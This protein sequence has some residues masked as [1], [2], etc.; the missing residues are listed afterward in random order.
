M[1]EEMTWKLNDALERHVREFNQCNT[2][3]HSFRE[4]YS[5]ELEESRQKSTKVVREL[6]SEAAAAIASS[7]MAFSMAMEWKGE[8]ETYRVHSQEIAKKELEAAHEET[9][10][11]LEALES[12]RRSDLSESVE[13]RTKLLSECDL[14][15]KREV[16]RLIEE[17]TN[18]MDK[19]ELSHIKV[20]EETI[21][22]KEEELSAAE[23]KREADLEE[24]DGVYEAIM[25]EKLEEADKVKRDALKECIEDWEVRLREKKE[26][27]TQLIKVTTLS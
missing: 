25:M 22:L 9:R 18:A 8:L 1:N 27:A 4:E 3:F 12:A 14:M 2:S 13:T 6:Q 17:H 20:L 7:E 5:S 24:L 15:H 10:L 19:M 21:K 23:L 11:Q 16:S 26:E